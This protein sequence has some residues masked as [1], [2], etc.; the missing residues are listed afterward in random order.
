MDG[1]I[2]TDTEIQQ[3][4]NKTVRSA[5]TYNYLHVTLHHEAIP[6]GY[7]TRTEYEK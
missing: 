6:S 3:T 1:R 5:I 2:N 4:T 7:K